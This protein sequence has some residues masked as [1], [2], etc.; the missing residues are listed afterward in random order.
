LQQFLDGVGQAADAGPIVGAEFAHAAEDL[1]QL[2]F[3]A[4]VV[5]PQLLDRIEAVGRSDRGL[6]LLLHGVE[7]GFEFV[8]G[9]GAGVGCGGSWPRAAALFSLRVFVAYADSGQ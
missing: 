9:H 7:L 6:G 3:F 8:N 5:D 4:E 2:A 1:G